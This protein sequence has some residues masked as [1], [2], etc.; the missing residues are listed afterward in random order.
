[1]N[2]RKDTLHRFCKV[3]SVG[4]CLL[5]LACLSMSAMHKK[6]L[7]YMG[8]V[9]KSLEDWVFFNLKKVVTLCQF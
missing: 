4:F 5:L 1:M 8:K 3:L 2:I 6:K 9:E 7:I